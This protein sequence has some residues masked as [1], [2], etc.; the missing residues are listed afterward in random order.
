MEAEA[1]NDGNICFHGNYSNDRKIIT[2]IIGTE[3]REAVYKVKERL[4]VKILQYLYL[5]RQIMFKL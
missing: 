1:L 5:K 3:E 2:L 4:Q